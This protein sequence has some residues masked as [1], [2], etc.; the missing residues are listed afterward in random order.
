MD[1]TPTIAY[2]AESLAQDLQVLPVNGVVISEVYTH[3]AS[4]ALFA[5]EMMRQIGEEAV[6]LVERQGV[7][8]ID[9]RLA[10]YGRNDQQND[11]Q[12]IVFHDV[13]D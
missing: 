4:D 5:G 11:E 12:E 6:E 13:G 3:L 9:L 2:F 7:V 8:D 10:G 1:I